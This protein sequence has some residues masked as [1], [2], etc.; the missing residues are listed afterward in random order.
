MSLFALICI[1]TVDLILAGVYLTGLHFKVTAA[2]SSTYRGLESP[3]RQF[4][5]WWV[6]LVVLMIAASITAGLLAR[7]L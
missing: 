4:A 6:L 3:L 2:L 1:V 7:A 5:Q